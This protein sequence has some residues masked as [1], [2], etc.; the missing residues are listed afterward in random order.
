LPLQKRF[1]GDILVVPLWLNL[2][3]QSGAQGSHEKDPGN[4]ELE[5]KTR[6]AA[7]FSN[8]IDFVERIDFCGQSG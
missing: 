5:R 6:S 4:W 8:A 3:K 1:S 7:H 2:I